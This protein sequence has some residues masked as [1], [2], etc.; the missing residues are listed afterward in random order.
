[1]KTLCRFVLAAALAFGVAA[2][3]F[4]AGT[5][6]MVEEDGTNGVVKYTITW[7]CDGSGNVSA[8]A[9]RIKS[10][11]VIQS[12]FIPGTGGSVPT[13]LYDVTLVDANSLDLLQTAGTDLSATVSKIAVFAPPALQDTGT[14]QLVV[15]HAGI[16]KGG[17]VIVWIQR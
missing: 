4:A 3:T 8:N 11:R 12:K 7:T 14:L 1:M 17:T 10:G 15:A 2:P 13:A 6:A 16:S 9:L 5:V